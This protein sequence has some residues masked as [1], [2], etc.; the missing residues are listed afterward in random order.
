MT[1][2]G[3]TGGDV[4]KRKRWGWRRLRRVF[5]KTFFAIDSQANKW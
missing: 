4:E 2:M 3:R 5:S 1:L